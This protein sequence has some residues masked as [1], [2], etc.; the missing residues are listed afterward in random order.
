MAEIFDECFLEISLVKSLESDL[1][2]FEQ[3]YFILSNNLSFRK[4]QISFLQSG[5]KGLDLA[6]GGHS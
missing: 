5:G 4:A 6:A 3:N 2:L 1:A